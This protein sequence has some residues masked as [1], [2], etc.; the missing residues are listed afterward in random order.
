MSEIS[1][2]APERSQEV[3]EVSQS[4]LPIH[5]PMPDAPL[6]SSHPRVFL[7]M[8]S[9]GVAKCSYCGTRY[10]LVAES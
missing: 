7:P 9:D 2:E 10:K 4:D 1:A 3:I 8:N 6:W 5:C